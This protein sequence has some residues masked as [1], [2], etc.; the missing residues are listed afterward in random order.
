MSDLNKYDQAYDDGY[1]AG[2]EDDLMGNFSQSLVK[3]YY[4]SEPKL[5]EAYN[6]GYDDGASDHYDDDNSHYR[7]K[8]KAIRENWERKEQIR[9]KLEE[10]R[11]ERER[12]RPYE[13]EPEPYSSPSSSD[14]ACLEIIGKIVGVLVL[15]FVIGW[16]IANIVIPLVIID[17]SLIGMAVGYF[18]EKYRKFAYPVAV[19]GAVFLIFDYNLHWITYQF[20]LH[21]SF[22]SGILPVLYVL[23]IS[24]GILASYF[25]VSRYL[26]NSKPGFWSEQ[27]NRNMVVGGHVF[28]GM[29]IL[30]LQFIQ[31]GSTS[32]YKRSTSDNVQPKLSNEKVA[33]TPPPAESNTPPSQPNQGFQP[34][35]ILNVAAFKTEEEAQKRVNELRSTGKASNYLW[36]P[37]YASLSGAQLFCVYIGPFDNQSDCEYATEEY[38]KKYP[39][40]YGLLVSQE[41]RRV[42]INGVGKVAVVDNTQNDSCCKEPSSG[43]EAILISGDNVRVR[44]EPTS[45]SD[46]NILLRV[47]KGNIAKLI[48]KTVNSFGEK[49]YKICY[50]GKIGWV[51]GQFASSIVLQN[52]SREASNEF[53]GVWT[54]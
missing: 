3:G 33:E 41:K 48:D 43:E 36:I 34:F 46:D 11:W 20:S 31:F 8:N 21:V 32:S 15:I 10:E 52:Q 4:L 23:N 50:D 16:L 49:W 24:A 39:G 54:K 28:V 42:Q 14:N 7:G 19:T 53:E 1:I 22:L 25:L 9:K 17:I 13:K 30:G 27:K 5:E 26:M 35:Y 37:D 18:I 2:K 40:A 29:L 12:R 47:N 38:R 51:S 45:A 6:A 44:T